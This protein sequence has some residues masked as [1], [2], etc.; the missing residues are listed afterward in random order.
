MLKYWSYKLHSVGKDGIMFDH[1]GDIHLLC[2]GSPFDESMQLGQ[3]AD[4]KS[5]QIVGS[6]AC[7]SIEIV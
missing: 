2:R 3:I 7:G 1:C 5:G 4:C 6:A